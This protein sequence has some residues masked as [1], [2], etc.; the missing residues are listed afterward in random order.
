MLLAT[1][2]PQTNGVECV[3]RMNSERL[4]LPLT[5]PFTRPWMSLT[6]ITTMVGVKK[7][8]LVVQASIVQVLM[9]PLL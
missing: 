8:Q 3:M 9:L 5:G 1:V 2:A 4:V 6:F 7:E